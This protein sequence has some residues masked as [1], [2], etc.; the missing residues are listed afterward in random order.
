M[1]VGWFAKIPSNEYPP[2]IAFA[3]FDGDFYSSIK[4]SF[5]MTYNKLT[6]GARVLIHDYNNSTLP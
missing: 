5:N 1:H 3:F 4:D 6:K 2:K